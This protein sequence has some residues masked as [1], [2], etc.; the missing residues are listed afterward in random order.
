MPIDT[1]VFHSLKQGLHKAYLLGLD[2][3]STT[4]SALVA[5][6]RIVSNTITGQME[7]GQSRIV[8]RSEVVFTPFIQDRIDVVLVEQYIDQWL[9]ESGLRPDDLFSGGVIITGLAARRANAG[10][11]A[12]LIEEK[13][14]EVLIATADDPGL[15][16]WLAFMGSCSSLSRAHPLKPVL[17]LDIGGGT[18]NPALGINGNVIATGCYFI[19]ARHFQFVPGSYRLRALTEEARQ[20]LAFLQIGKRESDMLSP[21]EVRQIL[22]WYVDALQAICNSRADFFAPFSTVAQLPMAIMS[23]GAELE[24]CFSGGVGE[25]IYRVIDGQ[26]LPGTTFYGDL[27]IDLAQA[28]VASPPLAKSLHRIV[29]ENQGR[30]TVY[31]LTLHSTEISGTTLYLKTPDIL[32][33]RNLPILAKISAEADETRWDAVFSQINQYSKGCCIQI[34]QEVTHASTNHIRALGNRVAS[35]LK[36]TPPAPGLPIVLLISSN[37]GK[38]LGSY[39]TEWG[40]LRVNLVVIDEVNVRDADFINIG[41]VRQQIIPVAFYGMH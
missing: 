23:G 14:G 6:A 8:Y 10:L 22:D 17:N 29:P 40:Q 37:V 24:I 2:F 3:G 27:G 36:K 9:K 1:N 16:S 41:Q 26:T 20:L 7:F 5:E 18:T 38:A 13:I 21:R 28:I 31:G 39:A 30:A 19:G 4:S 35:A 11:I 25:L 32:P 15:E 33:L 12:R 34:L